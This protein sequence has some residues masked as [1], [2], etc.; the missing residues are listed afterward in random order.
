M[1]EYDPFP[2]GRYVKPDD[3]SMQAVQAAA[4]RL[5]EFPAILRNVTKPLSDEQWRTKTLPGIWTIKQIVHHLADSHM[6]GMIRTKMALTEENPTI[7]PYD[8]G[9][10]AHLADNDLPTSVSLELLDGIHRKWS[11]L[12]LHLDEVQLNRTYYHPGDCAT[13]S[14]SEQLFMYV[15]HGEHHLGFIEQ[16]QEKKHGNSARE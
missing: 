10:W 1:T 16:L 6:N 15:H 5:A 4:Q 2:A 3:L 9:K 7:K 14:V 11:H 8:E 12:F 13:V